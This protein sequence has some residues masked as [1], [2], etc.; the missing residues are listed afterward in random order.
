MKNNFKGEI[1]M[2]ETQLNDIIATFI[3]RDFKSQGINFVIDDNGFVFETKED[4]E[5]SITRA[6]EMGYDKWLFDG[7]PVI[8]EE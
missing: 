7:E 4:I 5:K 3:T 1:Y 6:K 2:N 8:I